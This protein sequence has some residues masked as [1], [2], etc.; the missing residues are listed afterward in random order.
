MRFGIFSKKYFQKIEHSHG[1]NYRKE[2]SRKYSQMKIFKNIPENTLMEII[3][4]LGEYSYGCYPRK[5]IFLLNTLNIAK[6]VKNG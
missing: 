5:N 1:D 3:G 4:Y 2:Y 6:L